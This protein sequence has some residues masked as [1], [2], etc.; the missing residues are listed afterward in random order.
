MVCFY[1]VLDAFVDSVSAVTIEW[2]KGVAWLAAALYL[3]LV[4]AGV[5]WSMNGFRLPRALSCIIGVLATALFVVL[6]AASHYVGFRLTVAF[7]FAFGMVMLVLGGTAFAKLRVNQDRVLLH[8]A[9]TLLPAFRVNRVSKKLEMDNTGVVAFLC[10]IFLGMAW[11]MASELTNAAPP[12]EMRAVDVFEMVVMCVGVVT[13]EA[14]LLHN[15]LIPRSRC[16][17]RARSA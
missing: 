5:V 11:A 13:V 14:F 6:L 7:V 16:V 1:D 9:P 3:L 15:S 17:G 2:L 12:T 10:C 8:L 4:F